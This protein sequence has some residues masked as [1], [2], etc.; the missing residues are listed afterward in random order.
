MDPV[1]GLGPVEPDR[2]DPVRP[3]VDDVP[4]YCEWFDSA[5]RPIGDGERPAG[6]MFARRWSV[7]SLDASGDT[8]SLQVL[9]TT[10]AGRPLATLTAIRTRQGS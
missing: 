9:V 10:G 1:G 6:G 2:G 8:L 3:L 5:G 7:R 4:E